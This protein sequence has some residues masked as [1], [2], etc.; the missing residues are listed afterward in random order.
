VTPTHRGGLVAAATNRP[1]PWHPK[2][3]MLQ[4]ASTMIADLGLDVGIARGVYVD[5]IDTSDAT[6]A[7]QGA[8]AAIGLVPPLL[9]RSCSSAE[10]A[11][12]ALSGALESYV[13]TETTD[14]ADILARMVAD[15][16]A[17]AAGQAGALVQEHL[18]I[19][20]GAVVGC[21]VRRG[22]VTAVRVEAAEGHVPVETTPGTVA[23][24]ET[25]VDS[26]GLVPVVDADPMINRLVAWAVPLVE[27]MVTRA[28]VPD[29]VAELE[30]AV[31]VAGAN[32]LLQVRLDDGTDDLDLV[33]PRPPR[34]FGADRNYPLPVS[35]LTGSTV[36]PV[37]TET[38]GANVW[39][40]DSRQ[41]L[42]DATTLPTPWIR[43]QA[44]AAG[45]DDLDLDRIRHAETW[46]REWWA[47]L[48]D[49]RSSLDNLSLPL[50]VDAAIA[51]ARACMVKYFGN[52]LWLTC[53]HTAWTAPTLPADHVA[54]LS[55]LLRSF[56]SI[57]VLDGLRVG[58]DISFDDIVDVAFVG[59]DEILTPTV[60]DD[61]AAD[62]T[63]LAHLHRHGLT[64]EDVTDAASTYRPVI[65]AA[66]QVVDLLS[67]DLPL[68]MEQVSVVLAHTYQELDNA[69]KELAY[70]AVRD[71]V[72]T[73]E[74]VSGVAAND[75][76]LLRADE[77]ADVA[78]GRTSASE[79]E[80]LAARRRAVEAIPVPIPLVDNHPILVKGSSKLLP[81]HGVVIA[82][83]ADGDATVDVCGGDVRIVWVAGLSALGARRLPVADVVIVGQLGLL[84]HGANGLRAA[85]G[86]DLAVSGW[87]PPVP[88]APGTRL[89]I[90]LTGSVI[91]IEQGARP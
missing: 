26:V 25:L 73:V 17:S 87:N 74:A 71:T 51:G 63:T 44:A 33:Q 27:A 54:A 59:D 14:V 18:Q 64:V 52:P 36:A 90:S 1:G 28:G 66:E 58:A 50:R 42:T 7:V 53:L 83:D 32:F 89:T 19:A 60:L 45:T 31:D 72:L 2:A 22:A 39:M 86:V 80:I 57:H 55:P 12:A 11:G 16:R 3:H 24:Y 4:A 78:A 8:V 88:P 21:R 43:R 65:D 9:V 62:A 49:W 34:N 20:V 13:L 56:R 6:E 81:L 67:A 10:D 48:T 79:A 76:G 38:F 5:R 82:A 75:L 23:T 15:A 85:R 70:L 41:L 40:D 29:A 84:A 77:L 30:V 69:F 61:I 35:H 47:E 91:T 37:F 46:H 68:T